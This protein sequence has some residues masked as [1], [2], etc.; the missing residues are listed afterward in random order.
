MKNLLILATIGILTTSCGVVE[1]LD[2][3]CGSDIHEACNFFFGMKNDDQDQVL[4]DLANKNADQDDKMTEIE[5]RIKDLELEVE[6][7]F[8]TV[9]NSYTSL[10]AL[11]ESNDESL[12]DEIDA[13]QLQVNNQYNSLTLS[14]VNLTNQL[15]STQSQVN[16]LQGNINSLSSSYTT[17]N[18]TVNTLNSQLANAV[19]MIIDVCGDTPNQFDE[20]VLKTRNG[21]YLAYFEQ[22]NKRFLAKLGAGSYVSTDGTNCHFT[23]TNSGNIV[24]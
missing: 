20:V 1:K 22:G 3:N 13:L 5:N 10:Q 16:T 12:Q 24:Y 11:M 2:K 7:N 6:N 21:D 4:K 15:T 17:L 23:I 9:N 18:A 14:M 19:T 8:M